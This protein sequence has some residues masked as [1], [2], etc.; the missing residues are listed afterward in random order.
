MDKESLKRVL[1]S[2]ATEQEEAIGTVIWSSL[3]VEDLF[4]LREVGELAH[5]VIRELSNYE[6][7]D[8]F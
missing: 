7:V 2:P 5:R 1:F 3:P 8:E 6:N 4:S